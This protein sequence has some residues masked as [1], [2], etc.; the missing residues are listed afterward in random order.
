MFYVNFSILFFISL[1]S[2][3]TTL[4]DEHCW[5]TVSVLAKSIVELSWA[6]DNNVV[7]GFVCPLGGGQSHKWIMRGKEGD[8]TEHASFVPLV[9]Q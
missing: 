9:S 7:D 2:F 4:C 5:Q 8:C 6:D 1:L 3:T